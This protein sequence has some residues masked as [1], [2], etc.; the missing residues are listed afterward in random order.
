MKTGFPRAGTALD[1]AARVA[2]R[3][4]VKVRPSVHGSP[5]I[6]QRLSD[7]DTRGHPGEGRPRV[8]R[9]QDG[10]RH[11]YSKSNLVQSL[12]PPKLFCVFLVRSVI[13]SCRQKIFRKQEYY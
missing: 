7:P 3:G 10:A 2:R 5:V 11:I 4:V 6:P 13:G 1:C 9:A 8:H 12:T